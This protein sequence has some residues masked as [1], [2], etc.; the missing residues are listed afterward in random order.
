RNAIAKAEGRQEFRDAMARIGLAMPHS[1]LA[2]GMEEAMAAVEE[3]GLPCVIRPGFTLGG[4]GGGI[5]YNLDEFQEI[6]RRGLDLSMNHELLIEESIL[7]W[8]EYELEVIRGHK[9]NVVIICSIENF[10][11]MGVHT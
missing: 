6:C 9:D 10:D 8:K 3:I 5:A 11:P 2:Y 4:S 7:G 1:R